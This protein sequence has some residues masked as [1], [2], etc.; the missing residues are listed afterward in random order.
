MTQL[1]VVVLAAGNGSRMKSETHKL[2]HPLAGI[3]I[4]GHVLATAESLNPDQLVIVLKHQQNQIVEYLNQRGGSYLVAEQGSGMGTAEA[5]QS[6]VSALPPDWSGDVLVLS[7]DAPLIDLA[8]LQ[9]LIAL[10]RD[11]RAEATLLT[12]EL[13]DPT[14]YGRII[15]EGGALTRIVEQADA[16]SEQLLVAEVNAGCYVFDH[17]SLQRQLPL[18]GTANA[19]GERYLTDTVKQILQG[20][21]VVATLLARDSWTISGVNDRVQLSAVAVELNRRL[22]RAWQL[23]GVTIENPDLVWIDVAAVIDSDVTLLSGTRILG[24]TKIGSGSVIGPDT[25]IQDSEIAAGVRI[26]RSEVIQTRIGAAA[27]VGPYSHLRAGTEL[28]TGS[29]VGAFVEVKNSHIGAQS[30][31]PHLSYIGDAH[32][33]ADCNIGAGTIFANYDGQAKHQTVL[34]SGVQVGSGTI[35]VAPVRVGAGAYSAAGARIRGDVTS[36]ALVYSPSQQQEIADWV[37]AKRPGSKS[38]L[39]AEQVKED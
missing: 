17:H 31:V 29:K 14:G 4:L 26:L 15:R 11:A 35:L 25:T 1:A 3:P 37:R 22:T 7:G 16:S 9:Q 6:G 23:A 28:A 33:G 13:S 2:L 20:G 21:G 34:Q 36:G 19:Q 8:Q 30:K 27:Q 39:A 18:V 10:H 38:A 24:S 32:I 5:A 12:A